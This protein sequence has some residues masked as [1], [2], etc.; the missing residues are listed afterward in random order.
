MT[1]FVFEHYKELSRFDF[2]QE[3]VWHKQEKTQRV[4]PEKD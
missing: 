4:N 3:A 2:I 1:L